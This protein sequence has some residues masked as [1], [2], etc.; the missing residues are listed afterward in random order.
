MNNNTAY[1]PA[2]AGAI[3]GEA[4]NYMGAQVSP[5][6]VTFTRNISY[7]PITGSG[8]NCS[9]G[10]PFSGP[11][12]TPGHCI[13]TCRMYNNTFTTTAGSAFGTDVTC[14]APGQNQT[15]ID[16]RNNILDSSRAIW[17]GQACGS[18]T[19]ITWDYNDDC[20]TQQINGVSCYLWPNGGSYFSLGNFQSATGQGTHDWFYTNP[21]Y[22]DPTGG[23]FALLAGSPLVGAGLPNLVAGLSDIG[24][25]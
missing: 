17:V 16:M 5:N 14:A 12:C 23:N 20:A 19:T 10:P 24:A 9:G 18:N 1:E 11:T 4:F 3:A 13:T 6:D 25:F 21:D 2:S 7:G 22:V 8:L 15:I